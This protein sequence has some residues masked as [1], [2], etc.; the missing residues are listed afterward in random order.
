MS[1]GWLMSND[2]VQTLKNVQEN[3]ITN[4]PSKKPYWFGFGTLFS[5]AVFFVC[6]NKPWQASKPFVKFSQKLTFALLLYDTKHEQR[7]R[8]G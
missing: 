2:L 1:V 6:W 3:W 7:S 8:E 5:Y 4:L